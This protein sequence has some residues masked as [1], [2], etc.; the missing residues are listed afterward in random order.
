VTKLATNNRTLF[1]GRRPER[2]YLFKSCVAGTF[3]PYI[4]RSFRYILNSL[5]IDYFDDPRQSS[6]T[7]F[8]KHC[9]VM[10]PETTL[11]LNAR[12]LAL[13]QD[14]GYTNIVCT[15]PTSYGNLKECMEELKDEM[16][17][18]SINAVLDTIGVVYKDGLRVFHAAEVLHSLRE[19]LKKRSRGSLNGVRV[20]THHGC[21]Y[22]KIFY[23][24]VIGGTWEYPTLLDEVCEPFSPELIDYPERTLCCGMGF[25][26][27]IGDRRYTEATA[28][29]KLES[30]LSGEPDVIIT[31]CAGC[32]AVLDSYQKSFENKLDHAAPV[33]NVAQLVALLLG[34]DINKDACL[35]FSS[36]DVGPL[37]EKMAV[38]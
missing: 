32:Q 13:A 35:Q 24:E 1:S 21:H 14:S 10:P 8:G 33:L 18:N 19:T 5:S 26:H 2:L 27:L 22:T 11:A 31:M 3:C 20:A 17:K 36:I 4:E 30:I 6:C 9:G 16:T 38:V 7:G 23:D 25:T 15:C 12:N 29:R 34:G 28:F 37:L